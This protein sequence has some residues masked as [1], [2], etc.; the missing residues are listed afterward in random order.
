M[1]HLP[2]LPAELWHQILGH[3][4]TPTYPVR[5]IAWNRRL[6][7][8][9]WPADDQ[10]VL[11]FAPADGKVQTSFMFCT[12]G[13]ANRFFFPVSVRDIW[14]LLICQG[15]WS[16]QVRGS[17]NATT[18][19]KEWLQRGSDQ[20]RWAES[21]ERLQTTFN[22]HLQ[23]V[24]ITV[25]TGDYFKDARL[26]KLVGRS[27]PRY[28]WASAVLKHITSVIETC[29]ALKSLTLSLG[30]PRVFDDFGSCYR[31]TRAFSDIWQCTVPFIKDGGEVREPVAVWK[32]DCKRIG[33]DFKIIS[34]TS[35]L[36]ARSSTIVVIEDD[37]TEFWDLPTYIKEDEDIFNSRHLTSAIDVHISKRGL[38]GYTTIPWNA[39]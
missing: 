31:M 19:W 15:I 4:M 37:L 21:L 28:Q 10:P 27:L 32:A 9:S 17:D 7:L 29:S 33:V 3:V 12:K 26:E 35:V 36:D 18:L 34:R 16:L 11:R 39:I 1:P 5:I 38:K 6:A 20:V 22:A 25:D 2:V 23:H 30:F 24:D 8:D 13:P 14:R